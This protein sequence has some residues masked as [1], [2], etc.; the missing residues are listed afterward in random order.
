MKIKD[1]HYVDYSHTIM[2]EK[3]DNLSR[4][5]RLCAVFGCAK[6]GEELFREFER[7]VDSAIEKFQ[8]LVLGQNDPDEPDS[9]EE[10]HALRPEGL[11]R[12]T[13]VH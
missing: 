8:T 13:E 1:I 11:R 12:L 3:L 7:N 2:N 4:Y 10:I 6:D 9:L 5:L